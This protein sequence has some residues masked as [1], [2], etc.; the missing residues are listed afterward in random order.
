MVIVVLSGGIGAQLFQYAAGYQLAKKNKCKLILDACWFNKKNQFATK[1]F[2]INKFLNLEDNLIIKNI[3]VSRLLRLFF[4]VL[5]I[6]TFGRY[7]YIDINIS[8]PLKFEKIPAFKN[9]F[10]N[11]Y[12]QNVDYINNS[13][14]QILDKINIENYSD[15]NSNKIKSIALHV[16]KGD[17]KGGPVD[18]LNVDYYQK[19]IDE[20]IKKT[21]LNYQD[22]KISIFC[23][24]AEWPKNNL[25]FDDRIK[26][27]EYVIG[28]DASA[29]KDLKKMMNCDFIIMSNSGYSW[30][31]AAYIDQ[32][33]KGYVICPDLWWNKIPVDKTNIYLDK[34]IIVKTN[35]TSNKNPEFSV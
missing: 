12:I 24:E 11:G 5:H 27:I 8:N 9:L 19:G 33:K 31:A 17:Q 34:W 18:F 16:R 14:R 29:I 7:N 13:I 25:A 26:N 21:K 3:W 32:I 23:E 15:K 6:L 22:I 20:I 10:L 2:T 35:I 4:I 28:D 1:P 30:W